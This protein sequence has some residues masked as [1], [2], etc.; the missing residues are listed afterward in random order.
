MKK[1]KITQAIKGV[2]QIRQWINEF[3]PY[4]DPEVV[5]ERVGQQ[6]KQY[7]NNYG[8]MDDLDSFQS[9]ARTLNEFDNGVLMTNAI[10][11]EYST[12]AVDFL[13][14]LQ[15]QYDCQTIAEKAIAELATISY[16]RTLD[17]QERMTESLNNQKHLSTGH[18]DCGSNPFDPLNHLHACKRAE[19]GLK[20]LNILSKELDRANRHYLTSIQ[21]LK[22]MKQPRMQV[23]IKTGTAVIGQNQIVQS[24]NQ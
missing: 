3:K 20:L 9:L 23:N 16:I 6:L 11:K 8:F 10:P 19:L 13:R 17:I 14:Q 5:L 18:A 12:F 21:T 2:D 7:G 4:Y 1:R 15:K 22:I 24:N